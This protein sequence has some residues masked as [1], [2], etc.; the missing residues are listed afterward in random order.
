[1]IDQ[2]TSTAPRFP[3]AKL[4]LVRPEAPAAGTVVSSRRCVRSRASSFIRHIE[5][6]ISGTPLAGNVRAGQSFGVIP[7][8]TDARGRPQRPRLYSL[9]C[10]SWGEDGAGHVISTTP[11][12][13]IEERRPQRPGDDPHDHRLVLGLCSNYLC[14]LRI[15]SEILITGPAGRSFLLPAEPAEHDY[16]F[17]STGTGIAPFRGMVKE[18]LEHPD[19]PCPSAVHLVSSSP[20]A[21]DLIYEDEFRALA[22]S[23]E[24][25]RYHP[26]VTRELRPPGR[27]GVR[28]HALI[29]ELVDEVFGPL[30]ANPRTLIYI[31][32]L[33]G[34][35]LDLFRMLAR[36][37]LAAGYLRM[38]DEALTDLDPG[39]WTDEQIK[40]GVRPAKRCRLEVY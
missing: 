33:A 8:G 2:T 26:A 39:T 22:A 29:E 36:H 35:Q 12:R 11:K 3:E 38:K 18:L 15:G 6:D 31:C 10:P 37:N 21:N 9:A 32:G 19:G 24:N 14:D 30:L 7:P 1:M 28:V 13:V 27:P 25:F 40:R 23:H 17:I 34:M 16:L 5:I 4:H 20:Y